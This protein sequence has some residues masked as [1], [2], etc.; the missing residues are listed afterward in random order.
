[1]HFIP[2]VYTYYF[3]IFL[4]IE[5]IIE[6]QKKAKISTATIVEP[7]GVEDKIETNKPIIEHNI[8]KTAEQIVTDLKFLYTLIADNAGNITNAE[9]SNEPT[10]FI[11]RTIIIAVIMAIDKLYL[12]VFIPVALAKFSSKV[13]AN[14]L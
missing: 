12:P 11:A 6:K 3:F 4:I 8:D 5:P 14:I 7:T 1:M 2:Q 13:T 10:S 9:I